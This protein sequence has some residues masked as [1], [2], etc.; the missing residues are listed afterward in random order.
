M[1]DY[2]GD[3]FPN[4]DR[5]SDPDERDGDVLADLSDVPPTWYRGRA[6]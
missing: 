2:F 1:S 4:D 6:S 3:L 5:R